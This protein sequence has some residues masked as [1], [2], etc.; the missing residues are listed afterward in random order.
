MN[1]I[2]NTVYIDKQI[3]KVLKK[4]RQ[5]DNPMAEDYCR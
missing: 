4:T 3:L 5:L 1:F 2:V